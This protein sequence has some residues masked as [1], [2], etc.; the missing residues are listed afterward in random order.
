[1]TVPEAEAGRFRIMVIGDSHGHAGMLGRA[2]ATAVRIGASEIW[3]VGDFGIWPGR[4]GTGFL[5]TVEYDA[6]TAGITIRVVPGNHDDYDQIDRALA[7]EDGDWAAIRPHIL[8]ARRGA[9]HQVGAFR[10]MCLSGAA[11]IDGPEGL[12]GLARWYGNGWWPQERITDDEV[13]YA[14]SRIDQAGGSVE[15]M[16]CHD[17]P[18]TETVTGQR[19]FPAGEAVRGRIRQVAEHGAAPLLLAGHWH[20]HIDRQVGGR[21][22]IILSADVRPEEV[23]WLAVDI[24]P[25]TG[26]SEVHIP[27]PWTERSALS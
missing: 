12:W 19:D 1:M 9:V 10:I 2:C 22:E 27:E 5:D 4:G 25:D 17:V 13:A 24:N 16:V 14:N 23:Q 6:K 20:R 21:R 11:S 15:M 7:E 18:D 26:V 8:I 3:S